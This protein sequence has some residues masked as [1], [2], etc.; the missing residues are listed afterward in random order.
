MW[1]S[2]GVQMLAWGAEF[3]FLG[4][5]D[6]DVCGVERARNRLLAE[7]MVLGADWL[8]MIDTDTWVVQDGKITPGAQLL[9]MILTA[10]RANA[11]IV[12]APVVRRTVGDLNVFMLDANDRYHASEREAMVS[13]DNVSEVDA[14]GAACIAINLAKLD[15]DVVFES[16][17]A[18]SE[19]IQFC[20]AVQKRGG[21]ILVDK[22]VRTSHWNSPAVLEYVPYTP[23]TEWILDR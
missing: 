6:V 5:V 18:R 17:D 2:L 21:K 13:R 1:Y 9:R 15:D 12:G 23:I 3:D 11:T 16:V 22:R 10:D 19:D 20:R 7:A 14:I 4:F 8:L